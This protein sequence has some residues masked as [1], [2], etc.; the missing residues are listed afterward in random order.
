MEP[1]GENLAGERP[2][3]LCTGE[4][5]RSVRR[6]KG[7]PAYCMNDQHNGSQPAAA[8]MM[9]RHPPFHDCFRVVDYAATDESQKL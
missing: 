8:D 7:V 9:W 5:P 3:D 2:R 6:R 4:F 1:V